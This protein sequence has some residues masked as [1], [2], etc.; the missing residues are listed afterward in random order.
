ML[1]NVS[2]GYYRDKEM[3]EIDM[4][5]ENDGMLH[6]LEIKRSVNPGNELIGAF[7]ILNKGS[8][9]R[10]KGALLC[11]RP[12]LSAVNSENLYYT[13]LDDINKSSFAHPKRV[14]KDFLIKFTKKPQ[15]CGL[16]R[17]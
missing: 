4:I 10:G 17:P 15:S 3:N 2:C 1:K 7:N 6:P 5:I 11:M 8:V 14:V 12:A 16:Y 13:N 9:P